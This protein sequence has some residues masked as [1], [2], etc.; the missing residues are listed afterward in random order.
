MGCSECPERPVGMWNRAHPWGDGEFC[1]R[2]GRSVV[3][4]LWGCRNGHTDLGGRG[5]LPM[6]CSGCPRGP[7]GM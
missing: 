1:P 5:V 2:G 6:G 4:D 3:K 7:V